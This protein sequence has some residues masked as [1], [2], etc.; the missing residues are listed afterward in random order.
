MR[1]LSSRCVEAPNEGSHSAELRKSR[2]LWSEGEDLLAQFLEKC[3]MRADTHFAFPL[4][5]ASCAAGG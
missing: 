4:P 5:I 3:G 2:G 1:R